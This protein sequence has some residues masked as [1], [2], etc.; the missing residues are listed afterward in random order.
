MA[1]W[2][3]PCGCTLFHM[4]TEGHEAENAF[5]PPPPPLTGF[6][7]NVKPLQYAHS[8]FEV[9]G[10]LQKSGAVFLFFDYCR[11]INTLMTCS[12][13]FVMDDC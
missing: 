12:L 13:I 2:L 7:C 3:V 1:L 10:C 6:Q 8:G 4:K 9:G 11:I 5:A